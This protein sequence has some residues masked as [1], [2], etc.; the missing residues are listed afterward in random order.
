MEGGTPEPA[1][2]PAEGTSQAAGGLFQFEYSFFVQSVT[3]VTRAEGQAGCQQPPTGLR[4]KGGQSAEGQQAN[5]LNFLRMYA[6]L[7]EEVQ[8][9]RV[10]LSQQFF[11]LLLDLLELLDRWLAED[12]RNISLPNSNRRS[13]SCSRQTT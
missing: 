13:R 9:D 6:M 2:E 11:Q 4:L 8:A 3:Q 12:R 7:L 5:N 10:V 1:S